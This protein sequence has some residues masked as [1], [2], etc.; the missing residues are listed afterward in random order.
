MVRTA[1]TAVRASG[2]KSSKAI[3]TSTLGTSSSSSSDKHTIGGNPVH[4]RETP[5]WQKPITTFFSKQPEK[6]DI[7]NSE[8]QEQ[9]Q[10]K[11]E[12]LGQSSC[13]VNADSEELMHKKEIYGENSNKENMANQSNNL[14]EKNVTL[15]QAVV[16]EN[17]NLDSENQ[18]DLVPK[19]KPKSDYY[20]HLEE[21]ENY[22]R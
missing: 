5:S 7:K 13:R 14:L 11:V 9:N 22:V 17:T 18:D 6:T 10:P 20:K 2:G 8:Q 12:F 21:I 19:K 4:P 15:T 3:K 1:A 16:N